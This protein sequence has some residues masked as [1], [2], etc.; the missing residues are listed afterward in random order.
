MKVLSVT[1]AGTQLKSFVVFI[2]KN[3]TL[4]PVCGTLQDKAGVAC[5]S[6]EPEF[7]FGLWFMITTALVSTLL[8]V[9]VFRQVDKVIRYSADQERDVQVKNQTLNPLSISLEN[10]NPSNPTL[11]NPTQI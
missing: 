11:K 2:L 5:F 7:E 1:V 6:I 8:G 9:Y 3:G 10:E 4:A